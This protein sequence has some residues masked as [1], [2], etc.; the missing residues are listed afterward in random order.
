MNALGN[1]F[2][3]LCLL[4]IAGTTTMMQAAYQ[5][6]DI[7][8]DNANDVRLAT[9]KAIEHL[10]DQQQNFSTKVLN[11][12]E[13][14]AKTA[15]PWLQ[16][17]LTTV[18]SLFSIFMLKQILSLLWYYLT[19]KCEW[20]GEVRRGINNIMSLATNRKRFDTLN[21]YRMD[22]KRPFL[23]VLCSC[24]KRPMV[25]EREEYEM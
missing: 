5:R 22:L 3:T 20:L 21:S 18:V 9:L 24:C 25:Q 13:T 19:I 6:A 8:P 15:T 1:T 4:L 2:L 14:N 12:I 10:I 11:A 17:C 16:I 7:D 23:Y